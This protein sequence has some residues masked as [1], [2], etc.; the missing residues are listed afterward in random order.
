MYLLMPNNS[1]TYFILSLASILLTYELSLDMNL[2]KN[3]TCNIKQS[4]TKTWWFGCGALHNFWLPW[5]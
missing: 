4:G 5:F 1:P 2:V 3:S